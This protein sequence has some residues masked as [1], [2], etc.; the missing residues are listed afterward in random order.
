LLVDRLMSR[1][2]RVV[3][4]GLAAALIVATP[5]GS[6]VPPLKLTPYAGGFSA[7]V[8]LVQD[9]ADASVQFVVEQG[10]RIRTIVSG[11]VQSTAFLD[12]HDSISSGGERGL[13]GLAFPP[14]GATSG[15]FFVNYTDQDGHTVVARVKRSANPRVADRTTLFPLQW[16]TGERVIR[17]PFANHNGGCL[18]FGPDGFLYIGMGDGGSANDPQNNAQ[19][20]ASLLGKILRIDVG[21]ADAHP[22]GFVV[23]STNP[24]VGNPAFR[25]EIWDIGVRNP[26]RFSF[27]AVGT[28]AT[29]ALVIA[30]VGQ[31]SWE[32]VDYE[33]AGSGGRNYGWVVREGANPTPGISGI[34]PAFQPMTE[35]VHQYDHSVGQSI[36]GGAVYRGAAMPAYRGRYFFADFITGHVYSAA[37]TVNPTTHAG[38]FSDV[39]DHS[40]G[41]DTAT[42]P[43]NVS[44]FG[45][46]AAGELFVIDYARGAVFKFGLLRPSAPTGVRI[47]R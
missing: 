34:Q 13:L 42:R 43:I 27:D 46:N 41:F 19:N 16:S 22:A 20:P 29:G 7:P 26:W 47:I 6:A 21:V 1:R 35:P 44:S 38:V 18:A 28:G 39:I 31:G 5:A 8:A 15:R 14:D 3:A 25:P 33:P 24:F 40:P 32:E 23:P 10:G 30:D 11:V 9:P 37:V 12:I 17:Q 2:V 4:A 36:T 45:I